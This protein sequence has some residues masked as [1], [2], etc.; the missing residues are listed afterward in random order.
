MVEVASYVV[1]QN[2]SSGCIVSFD[3]NPDLYDYWLPDGSI[4]NEDDQDEGGTAELTDGTKMCDLNNSTYGYFTIINGANGGPPYYSLDIDFPDYKNG[5]TI[6][7]VAIYAY[8]HFHTDGGGVRAMTINA[9]DATGA[10]NTFAAYGTDAATEAGATLA[11]PI[12]AQGD[13]NVDARNHLFEV[14]MIYKRITYKAGNRLQIFA[15]V[16]GR[17]YSGTWNSRKTSGNLIETPADVIE[18]IVRDDLGL[19]NDNIDMDKFDDVNTE[20]GAT[21]VFSGCISERKNS[22]EILEDLARQCKS[23]TFWGAD[24]KVLMDTFYAANTTNRTLDINEI[25]DPIKS[26][27]IYKSKLSD[28]VN[29]LTLTYKKEPE[30]RLVKTL[31]R[32]DDRTAA[33]GSQ[34]KHN[35]V[36]TK[37]IEADFIRDDTAA[38]LLADHWCKDDADSFWS[39]LRDIIEFEIVTNRGVDFWATTFKPLLLLELLDI[40]ELDDADFDSV[41]KLNGQSWSGVQFKIFY[42]ERRKLGMKIKAFSV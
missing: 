6:S 21:F 25:K 3:V 27:K 40:I 10:N 31:S 1:E 7:A 30:G 11:V 37:D 17:E 32:V 28:I 16:K 12:K 41:I 13:N 8:A 23:F 34:V 4:S 24:D 20:L 35:A 22:K 15:G 42:I 9:I 18:S 5:G 26:L 19:S 36:M 33:A 2:T 39:V 29:D 14:H 38:G